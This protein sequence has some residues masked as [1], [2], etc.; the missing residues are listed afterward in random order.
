M[1]KLTIS[2]LALLF[3][4]S[5]SNK[6]K[7]GNSEGK[8]L[9]F[10]KLLGTW[11]LEEEDQFEH[12]TKNEDGSYASRT[13]AVV[14]ADTNILEDVK[15][16]SEGDKW[17][18]I[19]L[20]KGQNKGKAITFTSTIIKDTL[21]QFENPTHDF[22]RIINYCLTSSPNMQ[23]FIAGTSDTIYFNFSKVIGQ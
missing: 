16:V 10:D 13:Y 8:E 5:C 4:M 22:P 14:G 6:N 9:L 17:N 23:A 12:W 19:T 21:V 2:A 15:I 3:C 1:Q 18:F 7:N 11:R 20:V